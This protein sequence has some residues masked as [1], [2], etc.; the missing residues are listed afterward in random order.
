MPISDENPSMH[1]HLRSGLHRQLEWT[2]P[3]GTKRAARNAG[4]EGRAKFDACHGGKSFRAGYSAGYFTE[5]FFNTACLMTGHRTNARVV[6]FSSADRRDARGAHR[7][8]LGEREE[9][10]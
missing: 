5:H 6:E 2:S 10:G 3:G 7:A 8:V 1:G 4:R 9:A